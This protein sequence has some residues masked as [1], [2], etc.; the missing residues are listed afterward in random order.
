MMIK[1]RILACSLPELSGMMI[2]HSLLSVVEEVGIS[3]N[4]EMEVLYKGVSYCMLD[5]AEVM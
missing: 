5:N 1:D 4:I 2:G 3:C